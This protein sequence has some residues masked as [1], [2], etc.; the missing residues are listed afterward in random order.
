MCGERDWLLS[1]VYEAQISIIKKK[2]RETRPLSA[3]SF[4][5]TFLLLAHDGGNIG[6]LQL[7]AVSEATCSSASVVR[8]E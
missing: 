5:N 2:K 8:N 7:N 4:S 6:S 3:F 1:S